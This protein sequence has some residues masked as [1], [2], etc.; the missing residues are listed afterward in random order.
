MSR[1]IV[2]VA[3]SGTRQFGPY[4]E[5]F[6]R[7]FIEFGGADYLK[8]W[9]RE[10]PPESPDHQTCHYAFKVHAVYEAWERGHTSVMWFDSS[11]NAFAPLT[12]LWERLERDGYF[13][14]DDANAL[15]NWS[16]DRSL[17]V[18]GVTRDEAMY[19]R[20]GCGTCW[21]VDLT[22]ERSQTFLKRL[23][24]YATPEHFNGTHK[25][26]LDG[27]PMHPRPGTEGFL[28][29]HDARCWGHRSDEVFTTLITRELGM[30][31]RDQQEFV[32]GSGN[33][34]IGAC[35]KSG[36]DLPVPDR[37]ASGP[38]PPRHPNGLLDYG[39][40]YDVD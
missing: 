37:P 20:L 32:G 26:R 12:P 14:V 9:H 10:W 3:A 15:G 34:P 11:C 5:R 19:L 25:S 23:R 2:T 4:M 27:Q 22:Q 1:A 30:T 6:K 35:V 21:G 31:K 33:R 39:T 17:E 8:I 7:T 24:E 28:V 38:S 13:F 36:Y 40:L 29:S 18:F 16:S